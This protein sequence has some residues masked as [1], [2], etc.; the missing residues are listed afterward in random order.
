M[1]EFKG[2][3]GDW[4]FVFGDNQFEVFSEP[5]YTGDF[6]VVCN[7]IEKEYDA[8]LISK[9]PEMLASLKELVSYLRAM[10]GAEDT[11][12]VEMLKAEKLIKQA[13][14]L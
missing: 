1:M 10:H 7:N 3:K 9:A 8:L 13:T 11:E 6:E 4:G 14:E 12:C 5:T 2:T